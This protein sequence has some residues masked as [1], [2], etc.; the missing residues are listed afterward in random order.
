[1]SVVVM[2]F[3]GTSVADVDRIRK[4]ASRI[5]KSLEAGEHP[6]VVVSAM[7][8]TTDDLIGLAKQISTKPS[9]REMDMLVTTGEQVTISLLAM[10]LQ[11][12]GVLARSLTGWQAGIHTEAVHGKAKVSEVDT[13]TLA[14]VIVE[15]AVPIVAGFQG[16]TDTGEITTL[17]RGGSDT[18]AVI[19]AAALQAD[20]CEIYTDVNGVYT[21][22][23]RYIPTAQKM[24]EISYQEMLELAHLGAGV[25]HPRS[26]ECALVH[27]VNL[28][29]RSS[30]V[31]EPGTDIV[32]V[33][34][35]ETTLQ[36]R[37]IAHDLEVAR[38][39]VFGLPNRENT[40]A[41][42]FQTLADAH[43]NVDMI[44]LSEHAEERVDIS[45]SLA[46]EESDQAREILEQNKEVLEY[47]R[48]EAEM[49]LAKVSAVGVG[50]M[51]RP[52][53][54]AQI[55]QTLSS[56]GVR[57]KMVTTSEI[58]VSCLVEQELAL[59]A[60]KELHRVFGLDSI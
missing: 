50:M 29:V 17:G 44:G 43:I 4:V 52:G 38:M 25:L 23:P 18:T 22:D 27:G 9:A 39:T 47:Q 28:V 57:I 2:K 49:G 15:G 41:Q 24:S 34:K 55:F 51:T 3:G 32:E 26:V 31:E 8:K 40:L 54:A 14:E 21:A 20:R 36:V 35:M 56:A 45:F 5:Q 42:L 13:S 33:E 7:G 48:L 37:G 6:V 11:E 59:T 10:A 60:A 19:L 53:V 58:K 16:I 1:M 46:E 12:V 30:F